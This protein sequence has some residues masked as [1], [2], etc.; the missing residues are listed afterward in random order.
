MM[1][2]RKLSKWLRGPSSLSISLRLSVSDLFIVL[3]GRV[4]VRKVSRKIVALTI[5][6]IQLLK[7]S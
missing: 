2:S 4:I 5:S 1:F 6:F 3:V 7:L